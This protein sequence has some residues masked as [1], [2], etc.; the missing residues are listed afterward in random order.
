MK[1]L[2]SFRLLALLLVAASATNT[3]LAQGNSHNKNSGNTSWTNRG[4]WDS[5]NVPGPQ[6]TAIINSGVLN[7]TGA[8]SIAEL[9]ANGGDLIGTTDATTDS[10]TITGDDNNSEWSGGTIENLTLI[11]GQAGALN[12]EGSSTNTLSSAILDIESGDGFG[13]ANWLSGEIRLNNG[14]VINNDGDFDDAASSRIHT[15]VGNLGTFNNLDDGNYNKLS[16]GVTEI[17]VTFNNS[18]LVTVDAG[19]L[20][21]DGGGTNFSTG[22]IVAQAGSAVQFDA[23]YTVTDASNLSGEGEFRATA[24]TLELDG[25]VG[26]IDLILAGGNL[27]GTHTL[28]G[29]VT[30]E[31]GKLADGAGT[32]VSGGQLEFSDTGGNLL[33][34]YQLTNLDGG[35]I[36]W[37]AGNIDARS[38]SSITNQ[39]TL[40]DTA[41]KIFQTN[42]GTGATFHNDETGVFNK[43]GEGTTEF[44]RPFD[45]DGTLNVNDGTFVFDG[46]GTMTS[47]ASIVAAAETTVVFDNNYV[48]ENAFNLSG[49]G[50]FEITNGTL[51]ID[52]QL[53]IPQ[54]TMSGGTVTGDQLVFEA[55]SLINGTLGS[56]QMFVR[57]DASLTLAD[58]GGNLLS[59]RSIQIMDEG[60]LNWDTGNIDARSGSSIVVLGT[61]NESA[62]AIFQTNFGTAG[63]F[64]VGS[65]GVYEKD[66][67][68]TTEFDLP[69]NLSG[70][71]NINAGTLKLDGKGSAD[72]AATV[73]IFSGAT[74]QIDN[75][76]TIS[77]AAGLLGN[78]QLKLTAGSLD[79]DG[80][81]DIA[82]VRL[83]GGTLAGDQ[84][85]NAGATVTN[86]SF[87][88]GTTTNAAGSI[89]NLSD[90]GGNQ[91][92]DRDIINVLGGTLNWT[93]G[94]ID[95]RNGSTISNEGDFND[96]ADAFVT[97]NF[98]TGGSF[99]NESTG[100][101]NKQGTGATEFDRPF[102]NFGTVNVVA[103]TLILDGTGLQEDSNGNTGTFDVD[104]G[105][106]LRFDNSYT[107]SEA[108]NLL[109]DGTYE[110][111]AGTL[112][113]QGTVAVDNFLIKGGLLAGDHTF[114]KDATWTNG[115]LGTTG[116]TTNAADSIFTIADTGGNFMENRTLINDGTIDWTAG[117]IAGGSGSSVTNN[118]IFNDSADA[119]FYSW[120]AG[121][122]FFANASTGTYN[123]TGPGTTEFDTTFNNDGVVNVDAGKLALDGGGTNS[124]GAL[125]DVDDG[126]TLQF[127]SNYVITD[128]ADLVG[129][130][131]FK[132]S[133]GNLTLDGIVSV[134][135]FLIEGGA[136]FGTQTFT[137]DVT[138]TNGDL[139]TTGTTTNAADS[140]FTIADT[141]GNFIENRTLINDGTIDWTAGNIAG[142]AGS[143]L[144]NNLT[145]NDSA[146]A[147]VYSWVAGTNTFTNASTGTYNK[148]GPGTTEFDATFNN[149]GVV[150]V[151][152]GKLVLD[153]GGTNSTDALFDVAD[154]A[155][156]QFHSNYVITDAADLVGNGDFKLSAGNLTLN[157]IVS[158]KDFLIEGGALFGTQTFTN[159]VTWTNGDLGTTG[160]TTNAAGSTFTI[161][162]SSGNFIE[163]RTL[164]NDGTMEW[165]AGNIAGG[166]G[167]SLTN[168]LTFNDS[169]DAAFYSWV[170]GTN[171]FTNA[172]TG[173]YNKTGPGTTEFDAPFN[174]DGV[175]NVDAGKLAL[176]GG[177]TNSAG[178]LFDVAAG[179]TLQFHSNYVITDAADLVGDGTFKLSAGNLTLD[180]NVGVKD[181]LIEGGAL[182]GTQTFT[183]DVTW[184]NGDLGTTGTTTNAA[185]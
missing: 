33:S 73:N 118:L 2:L 20:K 164:I 147:L 103:G 34:N 56:G 7:I 10:L 16:S 183:N 53:H 48:I 1:T 86:A 84:T 39:G 58:S 45:N 153:G 155:T 140:T 139:G 17:D 91:L 106:T 99:T 144:T 8:Q 109:G 108:G 117:N 177:G 180:G 151:D 68:G 19:T 130:G 150:N 15:S 22:Q 24:G 88:A 57:P 160:T 152:A 124:A 69:F 90:A 64:N 129:D 173:T 165:T 167:S 176:D 122:N 3:V 70:T 77:D 181:F 61:V 119:L 96:S 72:A 14:S 11:I 31:N 21:L 179:A 23:N 116:T 135:D 174:N 138:W 25:A 66:G 4:G 13:L 172:S 87:A 95:L 29:N 102:D 32:V 55:F 76:Y 127:H 185:G 63:F 134:T 120:V 141:G 156:L 114:T 171:S 79:L 46:G 94:S 82:D 9:R 81:V 121:S 30:F 100:V 110:L 85:F 65:T 126:A 149:D 169:A 170:A 112:E 168:N 98:G 92:S 157:G 132:L 158:V 101:Y 143:S 62:D 104:S 182:H 154:G 38:G 131:T 97:T 136:L 133:A 41:D 162:D 49:T 71:L 60:T 18:G 80:Q 137:N 43:D 28:A 163:N 52:G 145:F 67:S 51:D 36:N 75:D 54:F 26:D 166:A 35:V 107:I 115:D 175:V 47:G 128:A 178:A 159:D 111:T 42:F 74:L 78:G 142:G 146:D 5:G 44:D 93:A 37:T 184:T 89:L 123:K 27:S 161:A 113:L 125:F 40:N 59:E 50:L 83:E 12:I 6:D 148:T 105:A